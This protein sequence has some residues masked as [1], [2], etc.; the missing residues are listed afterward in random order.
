MFNMTRPTTLFVG[1]WFLTAVL[2]QTFDNG[3][4]GHD[5]YTVALQ[6]SCLL[7]S[8]DNIPG[9]YIYAQSTEVLN[10]RKWVLVLMGS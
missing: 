2:N 8:V 3:D 4:H 5:I 6:I 10:W 7:Y 1:N 9:R